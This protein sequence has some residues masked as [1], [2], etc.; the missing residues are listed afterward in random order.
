MVNMQKLIAF[1]YTRNEKLEFE[2]KN[3]FTYSNTKHRICILKTA[4]Q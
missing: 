1:L 2:V 4:K 3:S